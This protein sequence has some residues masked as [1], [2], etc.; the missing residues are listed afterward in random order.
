[1]CVCSRDIDGR[2]VTVNI[3]KAR[4]P[5]G[6]SR[7]GGGYGGGGGATVTG[8]GTEAGTEAEA[9]VALAMRMAKQTLRLTRWWRIVTVHVATESTRLPTAFA[10]TFVLRESSLMTVVVAVLLG[11]SDKEI[12]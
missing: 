6:E 2:R 1:M 9:V 3:A 4:A 11:T 5:M 12:I 10:T 8:A 7:G